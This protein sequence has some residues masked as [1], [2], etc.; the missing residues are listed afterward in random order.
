MG[1]GRGGKGVKFWAFASSPLQHWRIVVVEGGNVLHHVKRRGIVRKGEM[2][3][4]NMS[5][6]MSGS[7]SDM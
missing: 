4:G 7:P 6:K 2:F 5:R 1:F 3:G